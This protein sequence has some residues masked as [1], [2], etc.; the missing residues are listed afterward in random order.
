MLASVAQVG[1]A[2]QVCD[3]RDVLAASLID[4]YGETLQVEVAGPAGRVEIWASDQTGTW[5]RV[6]VDTARGVAC[7]IETGDGWDGQPAGGVPYAGLERA[8][9][10]QVLVR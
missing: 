6:R 9:M 3:S 5:S 7:V 2:E 8:E 4:W 1:H 10:S